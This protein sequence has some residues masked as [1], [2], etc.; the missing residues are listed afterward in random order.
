MLAMVGQ[1]QAGVNAQKVIIDTDP[2][3]DDAFALLLAMQSPELKVLAV[4]AVAGNVPLSVTL[5]NAL[6]LVE[7]AGHSDIPVA[8]GAASPL[9]RTL[10]TAAYAHGNNGLAGVQFP[11]AK[12]QPVKEPAADLICKVVR[13]NAGE[14]SIVGIGPL[15]NVALALRQDP[16]IASKIR[17]IVLMG[18]SLSG[19]NVTPAAEF[20]FYVDPEA[21]SI[22][23][24]SGVPIRMVG[25]DVTRKVTLTE[26][27]VAAL[28]AGKGKVSEAAARIAE[29]VMKMAHSEKWHG[30]P[31]LH[32]PLAVSSMIDQ[33]ILTFEDYE[34]EIETLGSI[35]A[36]ESVG[37]KH[38][39]LRRSAPLQT[40][41]AEDTPSSAFKVN[42][43]V[44]TGV[45]SEKFFKLLISRLTADKS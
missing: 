15:T 45:D 17:S 25:L 41:I 9:T 36:G 2:G 27:H 24:D 3:V 6:R 14:I 5:P 40:G 39:P 43:Q 8:G 35:T 4:T 23:F 28:R 22:V 34:V 18:G 20:N 19:G 1:A 10:I 12:L 11:A 13:E 29:A 30:G 26:Q 42:A 31:N 21:A 16:E 37:W 33:E 32:D 7:I 44:A 38:A